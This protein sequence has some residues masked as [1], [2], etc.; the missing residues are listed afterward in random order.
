MDRPSETLR[1]MLAAYVETLQ[2]HD[3]RGGRRRL[4]GRFGRGRGLRP[5]GKWCATCSSFCGSA[6]T[7]SDLE[8]LRHVHHTVAAYP[9]GDRLEIEYVGV[10]QLRPDGIQGASI[11]VAPGGDLSLGPSNAAADDIHG[12]RALGIALIGPSPDSVFPEVDRSTFV[13]SQNSWLIDL[14]QRDRTHA[15]ARP[16]DYGEWTLDVARCLFGIEHREGCTKQR[17]A[18]W[19]GERAPDLRGTLTKALDIR[20]RTTGTTIEPREFRESSRTGLW[21]SGD[22]PEPWPRLR[23]PR[24]PALY[25]PRRLR[26]PMGARHH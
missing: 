6:P 15:D 25:R 7:E 24:P 16:D 4:R 2:S 13:A 14:S 22:I 26:V 3:P 17:A 10:E 5:R 18:A 8:L 20:R 1:P 12:A 9:Y 23:C 21:C 19:L 11:S